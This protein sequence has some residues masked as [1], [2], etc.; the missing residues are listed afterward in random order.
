MLQSGD[1]IEAVGFKSP[2][3]MTNGFTHG[4][5]NSPWVFSCLNQAW[6]SASS[7]APVTRQMRQ[8][9]RISAPI[10]W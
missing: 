5:A 4:A 10:D 8:S 1:Y 2:L 9:G 3:P 7:D 6:A